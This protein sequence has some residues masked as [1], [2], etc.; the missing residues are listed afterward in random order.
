MQSVEA[1][2]AGHAADSK[3]RPLSAPHAAAHALEES[4]TLPTQDL[5]K[6]GMVFLEVFSCSWFC[7]ALCGVTMGIRYGARCEQVGKSLLALAPAE[8]PMAAWQ[9]R[10][11]R[12]RP[13]ASSDSQTEQQPMRASTRLL[14]RPPPSTFMRPS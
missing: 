5:I 12:F 4:G 8:P 13:A 14:S 9:Q 1:S 3:A 7:G 6:G 10:H 2:I 11:C